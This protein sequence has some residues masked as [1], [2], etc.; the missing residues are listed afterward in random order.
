[1]VG[2][3]GEMQVHQKDC[4]FALSI[5]AVTYEVKTELSVHSLTAKN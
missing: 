5:V 1:M 3:S 4:A 2:E